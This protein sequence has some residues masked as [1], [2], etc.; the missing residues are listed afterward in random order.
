MILS[1]PLPP[2]DVRAEVCAHIPWAEHGVWQALIGGRTNASWRVDGSE[3]Q[4]AVLK[5]YRDKTDNPLFPNDAGAEATLLRHLAGKSIAP[6]WIA[7]F[8]SSGADCNLYHALP[9]EP[10]TDGV[11]K[12]ADLV[13]RVHA[14]EPP[15]GLRSAANGSAELM[16]QANAIFAKSGQS[17]QTPSVESRVAPSDNKVM[18][19][20]DIVPGNLILSENGLRLIDW[21]C[22]AI[23]DPTED[24]AV[25]LS[26][27]MQLLYRGATLSEQ[28][29]QGFLR[30]F[31]DAQQMRY[32]ALAPLYHYRMSAY[33]QWQIE[34]ENLAYKEALEAEL[35]AL[36]PA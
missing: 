5:L 19:H 32:H 31:D 6:D 12:V 8:Q 26:P 15:S 25:F 22:P 13:K 27:A 2:S 18:L 35:N 7:S 10:W 4:S 14:I 1:H 9:G 24:L 29:T 36:Y 20:C 11:K 33:C 16:Q 34:R 3:G 30:Q 28:E 21:Q 17:L 23:G